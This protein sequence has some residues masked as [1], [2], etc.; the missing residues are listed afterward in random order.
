MT[1]EEYCDYSTIGILR[2]ER[3]ELGAT[4]ALADEEE[5]L[6]AKQQRARGGDGASLP[7]EESSVRARARVVAGLAPWL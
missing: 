4:R 6:R 7:R 2:A 1:H 3:A 5:Q